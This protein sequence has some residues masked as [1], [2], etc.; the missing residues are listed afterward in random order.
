[1]KKLLLF[2]CTLFL[3]YGC[4][5]T[6]LTDKAESSKIFFSM[7]VTEADPLSLVI[8]TSNRRIQ[9]ESA[10]IL[11]G[12]Q[13]V[14][15]IKLDSFRMGMFV[16]AL[17][18]GKYNINLKNAGGQD[19]LDFHIS[20]YSTTTDPAIFLNQVKTKMNQIADSMELFQKTGI[21]STS[22]L[23]FLHKLNLRALD[24]EKRLTATEQKSLYF[25]LKQYIPNSHYLNGTTSDTA[26]KTPDIDQP[27]YLADQLDQITHNILTLHQNLNQL[28]NLNST[29]SKFWERRSDLF[30]E[31]AYIYSLQIY[32]AQKLEAF[33][34]KKQI[35]S[36]ACIA[37]GRL[38][39]TDL[40]GTSPSVIKAIRGRSVTQ[41]IQ[42]LF[43]TINNKDL[44]LLSGNIG[45]IYSNENTLVNYDSQIREQWNTLYQQYNESLKEVPSEYP[46]YSS[47]LPTISKTK[48]ADISAGS[49]AL[50]RVT[51]PSI[52]VSTSETDKGFLK[53]SFSSNDTA[54]AD[55]TRFTVRITYFQERFN[56]SVSLSQDLIFENYANEIIGGKIWMQENTNV[57][58]FRNGESI[59]YVSWGPTWAT[60]KTPAWCY[61]NNDP[62]SEA[63]YGL[64]YNWYAVN[65]PRGFAPAGW[66]V[67]TDA[68]W[69]DLISFLG[70]SAVAGGK[71]KA[72]SPLW[73]NPNTGA[74]NSSGFTALPAGTRGNGGRYFN[75]G[76]GSAWWTAN[77]YG[78]NGSWS[79]Y[80]NYNTAAATR[81]GAS[82]QDGYSVR[83]VKD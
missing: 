49:L 58:F 10:Q 67:A 57:K 36:Y 5:K 73:N 43:R 37:E 74:T 78:P 7:D 35:S 28:T 9:Q 76:A 33:V 16:P 68:E 60:L 26:L 27:L 17:P 61:Y 21:L 24:I 23:S 75:L 12:D 50:T 19:S 70:G 34:L 39:N 56:R 62:A 30:Y 82:K 18:A 83:C 51:N 2:L 81:G 77:Q 42:A 20:P 69:K 66:H 14:L 54:L 53:M 63:T 38:L 6:E 40:N 3:F 13:P 48:I 52:I 22:E 41:K 59:P 46:V 32:L 45:K 47:P 25:L 4:K 11:F 64:L 1:M 72:V 29:V 80:M 55:G 71:L 8:L 31:A 79:Y 44:T 15:I 65:D